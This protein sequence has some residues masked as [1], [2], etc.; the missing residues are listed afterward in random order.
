MVDP[1]RQNEYSIAAV[2]K[3]TGVSC[4]AL[5]VW[6]RR[7][8]YPRPHRSV[9]NQ[10]R[11]GLDQVHSLLKLSDLVHT[12]RPI[13]ELIAD[14]LAGRLQFESPSL[15]ETSETADHAATG[16]VDVLLAGDIVAGDAMVARLT[17]R[18]SPSEMLSR[19]YE[20]ALIDVGER[21]FRGA[22]SV[23]Q[24]H[25]AT[26]VLL[27]KLGRM[28]DDAR[29][30]NVGP[31]HRAIVAA[32]QGD[33]HEGGVLILSTLLELSGWR[34]LTLGVDIPVA[35]LRKAAEA[36][37]PDAIGVSFVLSRNMNKRFQELATIQGTPIFVGGRSLMYHK[38]VARR[39]GFSPLSGPVTAAL[40][41]WIDQFHRRE[42]GEHPPEIAGPS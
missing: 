40:P 39:Y 27:R 9:S 16:L 42:T 14:L 21:W 18:Y 19:V 6:E 11:Y 5:R 24:E 1:P 7:Y 23:Y 13:G 31:S 41:H 35:E 10:R 3:L 28:L 15:P 2:S 32:V 33:R 22:A 12:G 25:L 38:S 30:C 4:H 36:W 8:G 37:R 17:D 20:P 26:G 34:V 29:A